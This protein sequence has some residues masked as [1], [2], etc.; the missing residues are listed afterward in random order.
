MQKPH[1]MHCSQSTGHSHAGICVCFQDN[2]SVSVTV[3]RYHHRRDKITVRSFVS[4]PPSPLTLISVEYLTVTLCKRRGNGWYL[5]AG[6]RAA[7]F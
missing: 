3:R 4:K 5:Q 7:S 2:V 1:R 6:E